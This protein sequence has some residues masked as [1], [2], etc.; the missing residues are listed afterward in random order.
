MLRYVMSCD[1]VWYGVMWYGSM[2]CYVMRWDATLFYMMSCS[3]MWFGAMWYG[4]MWCY[5]TPCDFVFRLVMRYYVT[6]CLCCCV[7]LCDA[8]VLCDIV[9]LYYVTLCEGLWFYDT[10]KTSQREWQHEAKPGFWINIF[11]SP[12]FL[13][14]FNLSI[15]FVLLGLLSNSF[16]AGAGHALCLGS[17]DFSEV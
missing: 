11:S 3:I 1:I 14:N 6:W 13:Y 10:F 9:M 4:D 5:V 17:T 8:V 15:F 7:A 2:W 12:D 16:S